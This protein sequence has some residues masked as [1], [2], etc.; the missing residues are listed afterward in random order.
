MNGMESRASR[1]GFPTF[2]MHVQMHRIRFGLV[3]TAHFTRVNG[4]RWMA[5]DGDASLSEAGQKRGAE[6]NVSMVE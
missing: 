6:E 2:S 4:G 1:A 3:N 5:E